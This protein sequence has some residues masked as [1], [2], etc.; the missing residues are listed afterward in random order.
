M[1]PLRDLLL[2]PRPDEGAAVGDAP[3]VTRAA[4][5]V[6]QAAAAAPQ[7]ASAAPSLGLLA[8]ARELPAVAAAVGL[9]LARAA[10]AALV[11]VRAA[12]EASDRSAPGALAAAP[13]FSAPPR[14]AAARLVASLDARG[15]QAH[16]RGRIAVVGLPCG[17][18]GDDDADALAAAAGRALA[19][20]G[21]LPTVLAVAA[22]DA[23]V[24]GL[25][26]SRDAI[27][28][29][30]GPASTPELARLALAGAARLGP[31]AAAMTVAL[32]PVQRALALA[33]V[34]APRSIRDAVAG[35]VG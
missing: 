32:D 33:G 13:A 22:R 5:A 20:A 31:P 21:V 14:G 3:E 34:R 9:A 10:P 25:L 28:V 11:C 23:E 6:P 27:L 17:G 24:D 15:L 8:P 2:A 30:A 26:A 35:L 16:G 4:R 18:D 12:A 7:G 1:S 29:A 19:A